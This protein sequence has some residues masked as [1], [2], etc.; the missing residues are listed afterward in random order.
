MKCCAVKLLVKSFAVRLLV[1][2]GIGQTCTWRVDLKRSA[3]IK[4]QVYK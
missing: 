4:V 1:K 2:C 3:H